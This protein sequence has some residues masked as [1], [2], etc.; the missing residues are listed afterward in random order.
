MSIE[1]GVN[2][3][4]I[5]FVSLAESVFERI[6]N[7][8]LSGKYKKGETFTESRLSELFG[9]SRTPI[10]E[11]I[12]K[13]EQENLI[14]VTTKGVEILGVSPGDIEDIYEIRGRIEGLA[15]K[16]C[17]GIITSEDLKKL[18]EIVDLQDFY[19]QKG[20]HEKIRDTDSAFHEMIYSICGSNVY[21][22][23]L[24]NLHHRILKYRKMSIQNPERAR[25]AVIEHREICEALA[26]RDG[27]LAD[28][29]TVQHICNARDNIMRNFSE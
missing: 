17:A 10:R 11:A 27:E 21:S 16:K 12:R 2:S 18:E 8:I 20:L 25:R 7:D 5:K 1:S 14:K 15:A 24:S 29:L 26:A 4:D 9:V 28:K 22:S 13:L 23:V 3:G 19:T 6:E